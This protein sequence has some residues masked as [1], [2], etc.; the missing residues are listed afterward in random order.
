MKVRELMET[1]GKDTV[2]IDVNSSV[3]D[4]IRSMHARKI[5]A[6]IVV[7]NGKTVGIFTERDVVRSYIASNGK[8]F[9]EISVRDSMIKDLIV[10]VPDED[11][12]EVSATMVEKNIRHL[13]VVENGKVIGML[14]IRDI[15][16]TQVTKLTSEIH[17]L[18]D[19]ITGF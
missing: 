5:S 9:K 19:Y 16:Q 4:A 7:E 1:K 12:H 6:I 10:A 18:K 13:P 3:D 14:S 17:Y 15:I 8:N 11:L 2:S